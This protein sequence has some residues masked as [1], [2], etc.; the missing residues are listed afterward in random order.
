MALYTPVTASPAFPV[1]RTASA[2][3]ILW[4]LQES[5]YK[6]ILPFLVGTRHSLADLAGF[7]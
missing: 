2:F 7:N 4:L 5:L 1:F 3:A 6:D